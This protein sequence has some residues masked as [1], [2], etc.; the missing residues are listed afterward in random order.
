[1]RGDTFSRLAAITC[2][3]P[4]RFRHARRSSAIKLPQLRFRLG[5]FNR[6]LGRSTLSD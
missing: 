6:R 3:N 1:V 2:E 4:F 5:D